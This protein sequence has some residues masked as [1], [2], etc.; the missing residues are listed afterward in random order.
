[1]NSTES[2]PKEY[3]LQAEGC[4]IGEWWNTPEDEALS[5][6]RARVEPGVTTNWHRLVGASERYVI[7]EGRGRAEIGEAPPREV[8]PGDVV[9]IPA[10]VRQRIANIGEGDLVFLAICMPRFHPE[11]Y[12]SLSDPVS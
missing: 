11:A 1:M 7:L 6:A 5:V 2:S 3:Y 9:P 10:G 8:G 12:Q 4:W